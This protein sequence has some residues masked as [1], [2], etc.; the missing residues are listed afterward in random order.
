MYSAGID[1]G[2]TFTK[3]A[4]VS[5][6][7]VVLSSRT[8]SSAG[9][10]DP[11]RFVQAAASELREMARSSGLPWPPPARCG[12]GL[13]GVV[14][15]RRGRVLWSGPLGWREVE[16]AEI[17]RLA[18]DC[19]VAIDTDVNAGALAEL[20][21]GYGRDASE[22]LYIA[23]GTGIGA[24]FAVGR[25][26]YHTRGNAMCN[27]GH[28]PADPESAR[29]CYCGCR[30]CLE[31]EAG[32][33]AMVELAAERIRAGEASVLRDCAGSLTAESIAGAATAGD[34][35]ALRI[36]SRSATL[37]ARAL[38]GLLAFL[39]PDTVV[40]GGGVSQ[41]LPLVAD[42]FQ[43]ELRLRTPE[44]SFPLTRVFQSRFAGLAGVIGAATLPRNAES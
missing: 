30:G 25:R 28:M 13:P 26:L 10:E 17:G 29:L 11:E 22:L 3:L 15:H 31:V 42:V 2:G 32:G 16:L 24:G 36:V 9:C 35:L 27:F 41:C 12:I 5:S 39:N 7:G 33:K 43:R 38:A 18:L 37:I 34:A 1:I 4:L 20:Y 8:P 14:D 40:V 21:F 19:P 6:E 23:W 44:F